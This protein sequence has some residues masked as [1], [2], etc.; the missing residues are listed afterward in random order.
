[1]Y[2]R[3]VKYKLW[4]KRASSYSPYEEGTFLQFGLDAKEGLGSYSVA[5]IEKTDGNVVMVG[6]SSF[7]FTDKQPGKSPGRELLLKKFS[8]LFE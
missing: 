6:V 3:P 4:D 2:G 8:F 5:L 1:M 7:Q